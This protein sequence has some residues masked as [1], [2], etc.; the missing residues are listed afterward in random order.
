LK[1]LLALFFTLYLM[2]CEVTFTD[3]SML[4]VGGGSLTVDERIDLVDSVIAHL[5]A[6]DFESKVLNASKEI[7]LSLIRKIDVIRIVQN[8]KVYLQCNVDADSK[9]SSTIEKKCANLLM[10][11][12]MDFFKDRN[13]P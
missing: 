7:D 10:L 2:G 1:I 5:H 8:E 3:P 9:I 6:N 11:E 4:E 13:K 12:L